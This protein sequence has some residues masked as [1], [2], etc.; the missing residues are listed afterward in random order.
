MTDPQRQNPNITSA[1]KC[2][3]TNSKARRTSTATDIAQFEASVDKEDFPDILAHYQPAENEPGRR[4]EQ[5]IRDEPSRRRAHHPWHDR[6][7]ERQKIR[8]RSHLQSRQPWLQQTAQ[9]K[10]TSGNPLAA[11]AKKD[12]SPDPAARQQPRVTNARRAAVRDP[13]DPADLGAK[14]TLEPDAELLGLWIKG[15]VRRGRRLPPKLRTTDRKLPAHQRTVRR[16]LQDGTVCNTYEE[17][18]HHV[19]LANLRS[20]EQLSETISVHERFK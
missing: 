4:R 20:S 19:L 10:T 11:Q 7:K 2:H 17:F 12:A 9:Q 13:A 5:K 18:E 16:I 15:N 14:L 6:Q 8:Q 1:P 3:R